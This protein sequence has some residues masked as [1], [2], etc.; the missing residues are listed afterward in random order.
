MNLD[1][2]KVKWDDILRKSQYDDQSRRFVAFCIWNNEKEKWGIKPT[3]QQLS[4]ALKLSHVDDKHALCKV[5]NNCSH[6]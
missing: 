6:I 5:C 3:F 2:S 1:L 4:D